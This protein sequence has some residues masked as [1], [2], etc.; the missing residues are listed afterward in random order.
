MSGSI[1]SSTVVMHPHTIVT[2][3]VVA[4][5]LLTCA[6]LIAR[7]PNR[8]PRRRRRTGIQE[9]GPAK[10]MDELCP[11]GWQARITMLGWRAPAP[12]DAP[13]A[14]VPLVRLEWERF[15]E[16]DEHRS[17]GGR[18]LWASS[19]PVALQAMVDGRSADQVIEEAEKTFEDR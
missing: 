17:L 19:I 8:P 1:A 18:R 4:A 13:P 9:Q 11:G 6:I 16:G 15:E 7:D 14:D 3:V 12:P 2:A 10:A 5:T